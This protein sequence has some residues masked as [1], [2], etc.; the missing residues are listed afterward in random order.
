MAFKTRT[1]KITVNKALD[2]LSDLLALEKWGELPRSNS[3]FL[4]SKKLFFFKEKI[5]STLFEVKQ[6]RERGKVW[7]IT[8]ASYKNAVSGT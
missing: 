3:H 6:T 2:D 1:T 5:L 7:T 8:N 4:F